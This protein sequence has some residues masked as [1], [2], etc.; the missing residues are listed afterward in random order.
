VQ[1]VA[2]TLGVLRQVQDERMGIENHLKNPFM[3]RCSKQDHLLSAACR[4]DGKFRVTLTCAFA[5]TI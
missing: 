1:Q 5:F 2:E 4:V 3:L